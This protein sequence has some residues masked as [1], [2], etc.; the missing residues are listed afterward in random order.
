VDRKFWQGVPAVVRSGA[1]ACIVI[2]GELDY[3][4]EQVVAQFVGVVGVLE[5]VFRRA[6]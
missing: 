2:L 3:R 6:S 1:I 5:P 4:V